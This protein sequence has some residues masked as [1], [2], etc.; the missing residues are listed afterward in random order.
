MDD[1][2]ARKLNSPRLPYIGLTPICGRLKVIP[3][4]YTDDGA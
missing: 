2:L 1:G 3:P 4:S